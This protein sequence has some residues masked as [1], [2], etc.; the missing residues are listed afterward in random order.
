MTPSGTTFTPK[1]TILSEDAKQAIH[2]AA[3]TILEDSG[4]K[5]LHPV[6][7][8]RLRSAGCPVK[9]ENL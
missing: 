4:M 6:A 2:E 8:D 7:L 9:N 3:L 1:L 5:I